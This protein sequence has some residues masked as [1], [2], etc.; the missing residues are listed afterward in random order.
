MSIIID[1]EEMLSSI[2]AGQHH[3]IGNI[4]NPNFN[5]YHMMKLMLNHPKKDVVFEDDNERFLLVNLE[6]RSMLP[7]VT[8]NVMSDLQKVFYK[9]PISLHIFASLSSAS[10]GHTHK[11]P[12]EVI[13]LQAFGEVDWSVWDGDNMVYEKRFVPGDMIY[14]PRGVAHKSHPIT[15]PRIGFSFGAEGAS[16]PKKYIS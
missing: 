15:Y 12:M 1:N 16:I 9:Q 2:R 3:Y 8:K 10:I 4:G 6:K 7:R 5:V 13:Y 11:D 14:M